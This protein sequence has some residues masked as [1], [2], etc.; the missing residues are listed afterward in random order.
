MAT[1]SGDIEESGEYVDEEEIEG[2]EIVVTEDSGEYVSCIVQKLLLA[3]RQP[4]ITHRNNLFRTCCTINKKVCDVIID[5]GSCEN[6]VSKALVKALDL[7]TVKHP[8]PYKIGWIKKGVEVMVTEIC[9]V[10]FSIGKF[11]QDEVSCD[12]VDMS[13]CHLLLGRPWQFD[14]NAIHKGKDDVYVFPWKGKKIVLVSSLPK[15]DKQTPPT[16]MVLPENEFLRH[17]EASKEVVMLLAKVDTDS[18]SDLLVP[19]PVQNLLQ[20]FADICPN[21]LP[22]S[23]PP[24]R[25][26]QHQIDLFP[27]SSLPNLPHYRMSPREHEILQGMVNDLLS[28]NLIR[29]SISPCVVPA[30]LVPKKD[31]TWRMCVDSQAI[32]RIT[33][34]YRFPIPRLEDLLDKLEGAK[35]FSRLDLRSGYHQIRIKEGDEWK[36]AFKTREGLYEWLVMP[37]GLTNAPSTFM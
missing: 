3:P 23:L 34:N 22:N 27:G 16:L 2:E 29:P 17:M 10:S 26:V 37:F 30:L 15:V 21:E 11:Y 19:I 6:I 32:N 4:I 14:T 20:K 8:H 12:V 5:S 35:L 7:P 24:L 28:K 13:A 9:K 36:T 1:D 33:V 18:P 25:D 31:G